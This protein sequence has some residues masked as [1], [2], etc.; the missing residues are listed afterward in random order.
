M[1]M[2]EAAVPSPSQ[3]VVPSSSPDADSSPLPLKKSMKGKKRGKKPDGT[4]TYVDV[5]DVRQRTRPSAPRPASGDPPMPVN[6][7]SREQVSQFAMLASMTQGNF[8]DV[9]FY[10]FSRRTRA[11]A[12]DK[13]LPLYANSALIRKAS[14][15]FDLVL[16]QGFA[17]GGTI[18]LNAP[19][20]RNRPS[21]VDVDEYRY[22]SDSD[23]DD[24]S[25]DSYADPAR[26]LTKLGFEVSLDPAGQQENEPAAQMGTSSF[27][28]KGENKDASEAQATNLRP[29]RPGRVVFLDDI[30]YRTLQAFIFYAYFDHVSF[31]PLKS[32]EQAVAQPTAPYDPPLCSPKSMYRLA[33]KFGIEALR[34]KA[35]E[36][37]KTKLTTENILTELFSSFTLT[38][39]EIQQMQ[40]EFLYEHISDPNLLSRLPKWFQYLENGELP[41]GAANVFSTLVNKLVT[42]T[43]KFR[44]PRG[45]TSTFRCNKCE[46]N[47][48]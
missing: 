7:M 1:D 25:E 34:T 9:K 10:A 43:G 3:A 16:T 40:L 45:C 41:A 8:E 26:S 22:T 2:D 23:L 14:T 24:E 42:N 29:A 15:H 48:S 12:V 38:H 27:E 31:A 28:D 6:A 11:G 13:P 36:D 17:E 5:R 46:Y 33:E 19:Y 37:I 4:V 20:P 47:V 30:A 21:F 32:Q 39:P 44:C 18:D 35:A